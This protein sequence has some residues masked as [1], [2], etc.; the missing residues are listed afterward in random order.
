M[1]ERKIYFDICALVALLSVLASLVM[2]TGGVLARAPSLPAAAVLAFVFVLANLAKIAIPPQII[3]ILGKKSPRARSAALAMALVWL[4]PFGMCLA[5]STIFVGSVMSMPAGEWRVSSILG[6]MGGESELKRLERILNEDDGELSY[7][8]VRQYRQRIRDLRAAEDGRRPTAASAHQDTQGQD[9]ANAVN[10]GIAAVIEGVSALALVLVG[11]ATPP[12]ATTPPGGGQPM[13]TPRDPESTSSMPSV[14]APIAPFRP[15]MEPMARLMGAG[16]T[17]PLPPEPQSVLYLA[18]PVAGDAPPQPKDE[19]PHSEQARK[20]ERALAQHRINGRVTSITGDGPV[21]TRYAFKM[22][23]GTKIS[24]VQGLSDELAM[25]LNVAAVSV[26]PTPEDGVICFE[27]PKPRRQ[28]VEIETIYASAKYQDPDVAL[29]LALGVDIAGRPI[30]A[31]L[32]DMPHLLI[33]GTTGSG[34]SVGLNAM[35]LSLLSRMTPD[36]CRFI[37]IDPKML[38]LT[39]YNGIPH[40]LS[41]VVTDMSKALGV[42]SWVVNEA[43]RRYAVMMAERVRGLAE[44]NSK[45]LS[46]DRL[47]RIVVVIDEFADLMLVA[48]DGVDRAVQRIAQK[49]RAAG[50]HLILATQRPSVDVITGTIKANFPT[51]LSYKV[52]SQIDARVIGIPGAEKLFGKGDLLFQPGGDKVTRGCGPY[53]SSAYVCGVVEALKGAGG[54]ADYIDLGSDDEDEDDAPV[55]DA[56]EMGERESGAHRG[57]K[58]ARATQ[59][60]LDQLYGQPPTPAT[61][62]TEA[63]GRANP[64]IVD[65]TMRRAANRLEEQGRLKKTNPNPNGEWEFG[66]SELWSLP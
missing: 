24:K 47:Y 62:L 12:S 45:M 37:M 21:V 36:Q 56:S 61:R 30:V 55:F 9:V 15:A 34:K 64:P 8:T 3:K 23:P 22:A 63:G 1:N 20:L 50:I 13:P 16:R 60:L 6:V 18:S 41:P 2:V 58:L 19:V 26:T 10:L 48:A 11:V 14:S 33:A 39:P 66:M 4:L 32:A 42:L 57:D 49:A 29:P 25:E 28:T 44:Y 40:L 46:P 5:S 31:D 53:V 54:E 7:D 65:K 52:A 59:W 27:L 43:E 35:I 51:R 38:E 17:L